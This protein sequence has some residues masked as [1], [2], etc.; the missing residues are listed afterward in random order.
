MTDRNNSESRKEDVNAY[1]HTEDY[2][3]EKVTRGDRS[4]TIETTRSTGFGVG[5]DRVARDV[6]ER[7]TPEAGDEITLYLRNGSYTVGLD[8]NGKR[9]FL[10][11]EEELEAERAFDSARRDR[12]KAEEL[13]WNREAMDADYDALPQ[14]F[15]DRIDRFRTNNPDFRRDYEQYEMFICKE[16][17]VLAETTRVAVASDQYAEEVEAFWADPEK[18]KLAGYETTPETPELRWLF[19]AVSLNSKAHDYDYEREKAV[20]GMSDGHSGNTHGAAV[21]LARLYIES[22]EWVAKLHGALSPLVG[23]KAY[24]DVPVAT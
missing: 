7:F 12:Q 8:W 19:W 23:S 24:G 2:V 16:A 4:L 14:V 20:T 3:I 15:K 9:V 22:P 1:T 11:T 13:E 21:S 10:C 17:V 5:R 6:W 18:L